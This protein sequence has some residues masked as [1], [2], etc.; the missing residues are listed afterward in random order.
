MTT[1]KRD[2][3]NEHTPAKLSDTKLMTILHQVGN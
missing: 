3:F 1:K 2:F